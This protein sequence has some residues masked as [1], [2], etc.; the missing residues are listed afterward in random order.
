MQM[1]NELVE[2]LMVIVN[3][4][5]I[6]VSEEMAK[7]TFFKARERF[8]TIS[9]TVINTYTDQFLIL[10]AT[11]AQRFHLLRNMRLDP[12][13]EVF[14]AIE[15]FGCSDK[16]IISV[17]RSLMMLFAKYTIDQML[18]LADFMYEPVTHPEYSHMSDAH[19]N[20][21]RLRIINMRTAAELNAVYEYV[22]DISDED[23]RS[24]WENAALRVGTTIAVDAIE[25]E[26]I[27]YM[28]RYPGI[29]SASV[30][31][32]HLET[33]GLSQRFI[34][35]HM[36]RIEDSRHFHDLHHQANRRVFPLHLYNLPIRRYA[37]A[38]TLANIGTDE[39]WSRRRID[40][41]TPSFRMSTSVVINGNEQWTIDNHI[42]HTLIH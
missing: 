12:F 32:T 34:D 30:N 13:I 40:N 23:L 10:N 21:M 27:Q 41:S 38:Y 29:E 5:S 2:P 7:S 17:K 9:R 37:V 31:W 33:S 16:I 8:G 28:S 6:A 20:N 35:E 24:D 36:H 18:Y 14:L 25:G 26:I 11:T 39:F 1:N 4:E 15:F 19:C 42:N 22:L 3:G